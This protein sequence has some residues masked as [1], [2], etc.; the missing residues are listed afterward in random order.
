M[1]TFVSGGARSGKSS[2]AERYVL[3]KSSAPV[4]LATS[5]RSDEEMRQR[6]EKHVETRSPR[7]QTIETGFALEEAFS[8]APLQAV[9]LVDCI[10]VWLNEAMFRKD[11]GLQELLHVIESWFKIIAERQLDVTFVSND[12]NEGGLPDQVFTRNYVQALEL[13]HR[14][15]IQEAEL[16]YQVRAG[17]PHCWKGVS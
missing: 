13:I 4:Y 15:L 11:L 8:D 3:E 9:M 7:F 6:I 5:R 12:I 17:I 14:R 1:I 16:V 2:F 10:T